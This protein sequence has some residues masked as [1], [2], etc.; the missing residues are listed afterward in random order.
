MKKILKKGLAALLTIAM[1]LG[2]LPI[3]GTTMVAYADTETVDYGLYIDMTEEDPKVYKYVYDDDTRSC[4]V[5]YEEVTVDG[6]T[7]KDQNNI[8]FNKVTFETTAEVAVYIDECNE[9][10]VTITL[11]G[12]NNIKVVANKVEC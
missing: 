8:E 1:V 9:D 12:E 6:L 5:I 10:K 4:K 7:I 3:G 11:T 2:G